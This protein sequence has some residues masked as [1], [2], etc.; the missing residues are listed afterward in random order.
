[1][2]FRPIHCSVL[3]LMPTPFSLSSVVFVLIDNPFI[4]CQQYMN[5]NNLDEGGW[6][7]GTT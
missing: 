1:M 5:D 7:G 2:I 4:L 6:V 3:Q